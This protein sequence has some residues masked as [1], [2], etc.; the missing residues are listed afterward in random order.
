MKTKK[1]DYCIL[2]VAY[3]GVPPVADMKLK[4]PSLR[5]EATVSALNALIESI[6]NDICLFICVTG[7]MGEFFKLKLKFAS[8]LNVKFGYFEQNP[9]HIKFG[10]GYLECIAI[11]NAINYWSLD[12]L[13]STVIKITGKYHIANIH[14]VIEKVDSNY[15]LIA[16]KNFF[17]H[18]VDTRV[19]FF[20]PSWFSSNMSIMNSISDTY[21]SWME[22]V[23]YRYMVFNNQKIYLIDSRP[24]ISGFSGSTAVKVEMSFFKK[25]V[26]KVF[27]HVRRFI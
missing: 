12:S 11:N 27:T 25:F 18:Q 10:T 2:V 1:Y 4:D 3:L 5:F 23:L 22:Q 7:S 14:N 6:P 15:N 8:F 16:W 24:I 26:I 20:N 13:F 9:E 21:G 17:E 19:I